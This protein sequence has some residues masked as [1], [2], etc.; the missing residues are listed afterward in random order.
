MLSNTIFGVALALAAGTGN[1]AP[2]SQITEAPRAVDIAARQAASTVL[3]E[4][5][6]IA[7]GGTFD[8]GNAV[9]DRGVDCTGQEEGGS[10]DAVFILEAGASLSN[11]VI[12]KNS[13]S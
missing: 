6:T 12:G 3:D 4:P 8:G 10:S 13:S 5:M 7:A 11:V 1:A 9:F 2:A